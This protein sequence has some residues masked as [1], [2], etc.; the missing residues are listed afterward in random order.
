MTTTTE[1]LAET[2]THAGD[3]LPDDL[4][5]AVCWAPMCDT[6]RGLCGASVEALLEGAFESSPNPC[7]VCWD[8]DIC[9]LCGAPQG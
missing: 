3:G 4:E 6:G 2:A 7:P 1:A 9:P 5:H 8:L